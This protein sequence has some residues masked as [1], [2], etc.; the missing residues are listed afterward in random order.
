ME[1][2]LFVRNNWQK[3]YD[4]LT[5]S[6]MATHFESMALTGFAEC[7]WYLN[8]EITARFVS[9]SAT[10]SLAS[11]LELGNEGVLELGDEERDLKTA[12]VNGTL[13]LKFTVRPFLPELWWCLIWHECLM[14][15]LCVCKWSGFLS[16]YPRNSF[17]RLFL[18]IINSNYS[19]YLTRRARRH[20]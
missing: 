19:T 2:S 17:R 3:W 4:N 8:A 20:P 18:W 11:F 7:L 9:W 16:V 10:S 15:F 13:A 14:M 12:T 1:F 6:S 5:V